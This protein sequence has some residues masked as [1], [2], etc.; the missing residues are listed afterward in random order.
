MFKKLL[1]VSLLLTATFSTI[2][3]VASNGQPVKLIESNINES[4][5]KV[6]ISSFSQKPVKV[7][8]NE[9]F[10][11]HSPNGVSIHKKGCPDI[12][13]HTVSLIVR[14]IQISM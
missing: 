12:P 6:E 14:I 11:I 10:V 13:K 3:L 9:E 4:I 7:A 5:I 8:Q 2:D 1:R